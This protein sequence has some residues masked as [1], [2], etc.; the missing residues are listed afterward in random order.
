MGKS[1]FCPEVRSQESF[2]KVSQRRGVVCVIGLRVTLAGVGTA[3]RD[4]RQGRGCGSSWSLLS[5]AVQL[6]QSTGN[7]SY[8]QGCLQIEPVA[9][10]GRG[11]RV[12]LLYAPAEFFSYHW[13]F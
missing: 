10:G 3:W 12:F 6:P 4:L 9:F 2:G 13:L 1:H 5:W 7:L 8:T 11:G